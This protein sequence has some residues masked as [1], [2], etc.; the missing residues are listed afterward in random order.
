MEVWQQFEKV[1]RL[2]NRDVKAKVR[3]VAPFYIERIQ[4][5]Q[6]P[7]SLQQAAVTVLNGQFP[8]ASPMEVEAL[9]FYLV[10]IVAAGEGS[11]KQGTGL[12]NEVREMHSLKLQMETN[13][14]SKFHSILS[15]LLRK[16]AGTQESIIQN[17]K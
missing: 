13:R 14:Y 3:Q 17:M 2:L 9:A 12:I 7:S 10:C 6:E 11:P 8:V 16:M 4:R 15:N 1:S 5:L